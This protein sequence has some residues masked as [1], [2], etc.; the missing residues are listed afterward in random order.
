MSRAPKYFPNDHDLVR[1]LREL[2]TRSGDRRPGLLVST[3]SDGECHCRTGRRCNQRLRNALEFSIEWRPRAHSGRELKKQFG[4][5]DF[6]RIGDEFAVRT[7]C[8]GATA[9]GRRLVLIEFCVPGRRT[10]KLGLFLTLN[11]Y[12]SFRELDWAYTS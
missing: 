2:L 6:H 10:L 4:R 9:G 8:D 12:K 11:H 7:H 3:S 1:T 5:Y